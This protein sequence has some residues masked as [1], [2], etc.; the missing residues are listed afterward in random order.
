MS[1]PLST[2]AYLTP[3][4]ITQPLA[5]VV[6]LGW[7]LRIEEGL[8]RFC[9]PIVV[10]C[11]FATLSTYQA[12]VDL[13]VIGEVPIPVLSFL[14][15]AV[16]YPLLGALTAYIAGANRR[17]FL[18]VVGCVEGLVLGVAVAQATASAPLFGLTLLVYAALTWLIVRPLWRSAQSQPE[19]RRL[20]YR[21][22]RNLLVFGIFMLLSTAVPAPQI[23]G[24]FDEFTTNLLVSYTGSS[25][26][27]ASGCSCSP[28]SP[29]S[30]ASR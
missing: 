22:F 20:L 23:L 16:S 9:W 18:L 1:Q 27:S 3:D 25:S 19:G 28:T 24:V 8:R 10:I 29:S 11:G 2:P 7:V 12:Y 5:T 15:F 17:Q 13:T 26:A 21:K 14:E 4:S 6:F 30:R